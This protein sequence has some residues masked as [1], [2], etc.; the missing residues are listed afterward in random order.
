M[1]YALGH[2][3]RR[4]R[5]AAL[6]PSSFTSTTALW[7]ACSTA[8]VRQAFSRGLLCPPPPDPTAP[9]TVDEGEPPHFMPDSPVILFGIP[10]V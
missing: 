1:V 7:K 3:G 2:G 10:L 4:R 9:T 6:V 5:G 8:S